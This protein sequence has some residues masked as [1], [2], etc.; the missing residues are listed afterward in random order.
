MTGEVPTAESI[1]AYLRDAALTGS[2]M[3]TVVNVLKHWKNEG[4]DAAVFERALATAR[5]TTAGREPLF[6]SYEHGIKT[7][8]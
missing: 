7:L 3:W 4:A 1:A 6:D 5:R 8:L 2:S